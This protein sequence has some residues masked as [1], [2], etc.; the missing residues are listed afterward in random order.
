MN[1]LNKLEH[2]SME[3]L[4]RADASISVIDTILQKVTWWI[5]KLPTI[6]KAIREIVSE[7]KKFKEELKA[8]YDE[9]EAVNQK[10]EAIQRDFLESS[11]VQKIYQDTV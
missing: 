8:K 5:F 2:V 7:Y 9:F 6:I 11:K 1:K 4:S 3:M 10:L